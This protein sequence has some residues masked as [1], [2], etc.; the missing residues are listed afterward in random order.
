MNIMQTIR[1]LALLVI[2]GVSTAAIINMLTN[3][4]LEVRALTQVGLFRT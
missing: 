3:E 4:A 2:V 1:L